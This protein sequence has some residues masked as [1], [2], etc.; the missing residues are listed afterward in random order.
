MMSAARGLCG[1]AEPSTTGPPRLR[2]FL[3]TAFPP[4][5]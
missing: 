3:A 4:L 5:T 1:D 2:T